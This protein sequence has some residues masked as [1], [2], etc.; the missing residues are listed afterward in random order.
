M[1]CYEHTNKYNFLLKTLQSRRLLQGLIKH[2][3]TEFSCNISTGQYQNNFLYFIFVFHHF[4]LKSYNTN[5]RT[6]LFTTA[7]LVH[8]PEEMIKCQARRPVRFYDP[9]RYVFQR[10]LFN[11]CTSHYILDLSPINIDAISRTAVQAIIV[12]WGAT[13][14]LK[15]IGV[16]SQTLRHTRLKVSAFKTEKQHSYTKICR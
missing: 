10:C 16:S 3:E 9:R 13:L 1:R 2:R 7:H 15:K 8:N 6:R 5:L 4:H 11:N 12:G 14:D